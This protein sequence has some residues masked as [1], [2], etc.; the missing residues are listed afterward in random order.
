[1]KV[2]VDDYAL[3]CATDALYHEQ[4]P[5]APVSRDDFGY[6]APIHGEAARHARVAVEAYLK[7]LRR[8][9]A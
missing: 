8:R 6:P 5:D 1:M 2:A 7:A 3:A 4:H 9:G